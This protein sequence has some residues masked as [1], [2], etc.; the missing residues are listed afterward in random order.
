MPARPQDLAARMSAVEPPQ[1]FKLPIDQARQRPAKSSISFRREITRRSSRTGGSYP[2]ARLSSRCD[3]CGPRTEDGQYH[4]RT[5]LG[6]T[7]SQGREGENAAFIRA[8]AAR[9]KSPRAS[10]DVE[11]GP[12]S[13]ACCR[14][15]GLKAAR[16]FHSCRRYDGCHLREAGSNHDARQYERS[17]G[18]IN[19]FMQAIPAS[20][21]C[22]PVR[23]GRLQS[24]DIL[25][26]PREDFA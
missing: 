16:H 14:G 12:S 20:V 5:T 23:A 15:L 19:D 21:R 8:N 25:Q 4:P 11:A 1:I 13:G 6:A 24:K 3:T 10:P 26:S 7:P 17:R 18:R 22:R 2:T 9:L